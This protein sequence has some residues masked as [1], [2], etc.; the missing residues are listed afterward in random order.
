MRFKLL[1]LTAVI[2]G[3]AC[4]SGTGPGLQIPCTGTV[5]GTATG[6]ATPTFEWTPRCNIGFL[7]VERLSDAA[8]MWLVGVPPVH[9]QDTMLPNQPSPEIRYGT[10]PEGTQQ[11][12]AALPLEAG[13][14]YRAYL[15]LHTP[16][17]GVAT[18]GT[19]TF[20]P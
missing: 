19:I 2:L 10:P 17:A 15:S 20:T 6:G 14:T 11:S 7:L 16:H 12:G 13:V 1:I 9:D 8:D 18:I 4:S 3:V 5:N